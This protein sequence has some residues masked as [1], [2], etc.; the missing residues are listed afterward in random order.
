MPTSAV[1]HLLHTSA[2]AASDDA[3]GPKTGDLLRVVSVAPLRG[4]GSQLVC[5][6]ISTTTGWARTTHL[7]ALIGFGF[8]L[9]LLV[10]VYLI[11]VSKVG[12]QGID[13]NGVPSLNAWN[14]IGVIIVPGVEIWA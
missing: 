10:T 7:F 2:A 1:V 11:L 4:G 6:P 9:A 3:A 5:Q 8:S 13:S 14:V 12:L